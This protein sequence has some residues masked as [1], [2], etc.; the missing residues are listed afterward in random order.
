[1]QISTPEKSPTLS[2]IVPVYNEENTIFFFLES[3]RKVLAD[4]TD[5]YEIIFAMDPCTDRTE[6]LIEKAHSEDSRIKLLRFSRR[7]GQPSATWAGL[8]YASGDAVIPIDCDMQDPPELI[9]EMV[10]LWQEEGYKVV[11]PQ[12]ISRKG[13]NPLKKIIA[14]VGYWFIN[15]TATV[16][17][18]RN[19]GDFRLLDRVVVDEI[20]K[21]NESHGFLRGLTSLVGFK[22]KLLPFNRLARAG[23]KG[24]YNRITGSLRIGFN[25]IV[26]FSDFLLNLITMIG[27][28]FS[29]I[30]IFAVGFLVV[31]KIFGLMDYASGIAT[32]GVIM[33]FL[34]GVQFLAFGFMGAYISRIYDEVKR[35]P[36]FI[37]E[38]TLGFE[39]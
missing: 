32:L 14:Y 37:V 29:A 23:G 36:K 22:T 25:G 19:T 15:K 33:L 20:L 2:I 17:I 1:M 11:I 13:E 3:I 21:L 35:R 12:R 4:I 16:N 9:I 28:L 6:E 8:Q 38:K 26:A 18:P 24:K 39:K 5:S 7:F 10:R 27:F 34:F 30:S 31:T